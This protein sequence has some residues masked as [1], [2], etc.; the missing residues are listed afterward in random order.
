MIIEEK[1]MIEEKDEKLLVAL[2]KEEN[3]E[4]QKEVE[5][6]LLVL[7]NAGYQEI[8][9]ELFLTEIKEIIK[10][11]Q[12]HRNLTQLAYQSAWQFLMNEFEYE[13]AALF[14]YFEHQEMVSKIF[15]LTAFFY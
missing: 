13:E 6:A 2:S 11:H 12:V 10:Y 5:M 8:E 4:A 15:T 14:R 7:G 1:M 9:Q 3:E